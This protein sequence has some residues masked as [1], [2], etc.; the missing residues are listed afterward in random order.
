MDHLIYEK[1]GEVGILKINRPKVMNALNTEV[2]K[3]MWKFIHN[4]PHEDNLKVLI[5][6]G[7]GEK[8]FIA[9]ADI[10]EM[11]SMTHLQ[12]LQFCALGQSVTNALESAPCATI[13]AVFGYALGGG[14]EMALACDFIYAGQSAKLGLPEINLAMIPGFGGT[15]RLARAVGIRRAKE[16]I[17]TGKIISSSEAFEIN[18]INRL[19]N[20]AELFKD[21]MDVAKTI[22]KHSSTPIAQAKHAI[23]QGY[24]QP[25]SQA[26]EL[27]R[28]MCAVCFP[29]AERIKATG[30]FLNPARRE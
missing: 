11:D 18:L 3:E 9:G 8:C 27:E 19:C 6:T 10:K 28:N 16:L 26:L 24:H 1:H 22:A 15:Q 23:N 30:S 4:V 12:M 13:A 17:L 25:L 21:C 29:T 20:D 5:L 7:A 2:L 14:L